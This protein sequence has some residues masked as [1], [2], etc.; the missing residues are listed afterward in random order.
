MTRPVITT[1][2]TWANTPKDFQEPD[3]ATFA[4]GFQGVVAQ[5]DATLRAFPKASDQNWHMNRTDQGLSHVL[6]RGVPDWDIDQPYTQGSRCNY[7]GVIYKSIQSGIGRNPE[8]DV[9]YWVRD[10]KE[11]TDRIEAIERR[12]CDNLFTGTHAAG[13]TF[14]VLNL[15]K[16]IRDYR[17]LL[18]NSDQLTAQEDP[19][20]MQSA[21]VPTMYLEVG[22][23][24]T[25]IASSNIFE[26][27]QIKYN[28]STSI[29]VASYSSVS[30]N[31]SIKSVY[32]IS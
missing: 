17:Y 13:P 11:I 28:S 14:S 30:D 8:T 12:I 25:Y 31:N 6:D 3:S 19:T 5:P 1:A 7:L 18:V 20:Y 29:Q 10:D 32:G 15:S 23:V 21:L 27:Y 2:T 22:G 9:S 4:E 16:D 24:F 26:T